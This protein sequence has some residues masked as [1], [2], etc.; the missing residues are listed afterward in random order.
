MVAPRFRY[1]PMPSSMP[2]TRGHVNALF[3][4]PGRKRVRKNDIFARMLAEREAV[5]LRVEWRAYFAY[6]RM[7][8]A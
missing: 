3:S 1:L 2:R 8:N 4:V 5:M 7:Q 6:I